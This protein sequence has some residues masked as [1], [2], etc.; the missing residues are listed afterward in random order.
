MRTEIIKF[1]VTSDEKTAL[2]T[3]AKVRGKTM[4]DLLRAA[5]LRLV[6]RDERKEP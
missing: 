6:R 3:A 4:T 1:R 5:M 2:E